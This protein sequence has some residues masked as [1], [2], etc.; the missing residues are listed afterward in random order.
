MILDDIVA[1]KERELREKQERF[2]ADRLCELAGGMVA[3]RDFGAALRGPAPCV[4]IIAEIKRASPSAGVIR[5]DF[6]PKQIARVYADNGAAAISVLTDEKFF[7]GSDAYVAGAGT[8]CKLPVLRKEFIIDEYQI[9]ESRVLAADAVLLLVRLLSDGELESMLSLTHELGMA[10]LV[11][12]HDATEVKRAG[13]AGARIIGINNRDLATF[14]TNLETTLELRPLVPADTTVVAESGI[15]SRAD[16]ERLAEAGV[17][18]ALIGTSIM[19]AEDM[20]AKLREFVGVPV[21][22]AP[23]EA[24]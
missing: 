4:Q 10:A 8:A 20:G 13:E 24:R 9:Y 16:V 7:G 14:E 1:H 19:K 5:E 11:E 2:S 15:H 17:H 23:S 22:A 18:A 6:D 21:K 12:A 3:P